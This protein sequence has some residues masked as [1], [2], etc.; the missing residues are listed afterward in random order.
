MARAGI[1]AFSVAA[2]MKINDKSRDFAIKRAPIDQATA[3][4][5]RVLLVKGDWGVSRW[6]GIVEV[7]G[8]T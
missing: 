3:V 4:L 5:G 7:N 6:R 2:G 1:P 8:L